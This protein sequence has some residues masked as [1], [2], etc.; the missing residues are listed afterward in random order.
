MRQYWLC[1]KKITAKLIFHAPVGYGLWL[2]I[3]HEGQ[4]QQIYSHSSV[5]DYRQ[6][7]TYPLPV[8]YE[9]HR[10]FGEKHRMTNSGVEIC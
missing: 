3:R 7:G 8:N 2:L 6:K 1:I 10:N 5:M 9:R 4:L